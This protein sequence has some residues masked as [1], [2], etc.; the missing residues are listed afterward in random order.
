MIARGEMPPAFDAIAFALKEVGDLSEII[1]TEFGFHIIRLD[2][3]LTTT[4]GVLTFTELIIGGETPETLQTS[5]L[6]KLQKG[7]VVRKEEELPLQSILFS[8][9]PTGWKDTPLDGKHFRRAS[10]TTDPLT[11]IPVVQI[12]FD[13]E[14]G[15][16]FQELTKRNIG[17]PI[18]IFVGGELISAPTV[19]AEIAGGTAIITGSGNFA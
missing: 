9:L 18:A 4:P 19:Q 5:L 16:L 13:T 10:V 17:K 3:T 15:K 11:S 14:G 6:E 7:E 8:F 1:E 2:K 12:V